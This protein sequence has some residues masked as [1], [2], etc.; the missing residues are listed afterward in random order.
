MKSKKAI[1]QAK[2]ISAVKNSYA[3]GKLSPLSCLFS[4]RPFLLLK[5]SGPSLKTIGMEER[6]GWGSFTLSFLFF[7]F[8]L[9]F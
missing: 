4:S 3:V 6:E 1:S 9:I 8:S 2:Q 7:L 5:S